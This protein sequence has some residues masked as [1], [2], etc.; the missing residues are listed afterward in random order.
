LFYN[1]IRKNP[2]HYRK[3]IPV[4]FQER[5]NICLKCNESFAKYVAE[6]AILYANFINSNQKITFYP[7]LK[8]MI[9]DYGLAGYI[10]NMKNN[11]QKLLYIPA[12]ALKT[13]LE[14]YSNDEHPKSNLHP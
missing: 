14:N 3:H 8:E 2:V 9:E 13:Y 10:D 11:S 12:S 6:Q 5:L 4:T 1:A 7:P